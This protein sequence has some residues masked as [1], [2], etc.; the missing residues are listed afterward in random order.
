MYH[1]ARQD[2][3]R[4]Q[5]PAANGTLL[6]T[7]DAAMQLVARGPTTINFRP[8]G[9]MLTGSIQETADELQSVYRALSVLTRALHP[10]LGALVGPDA[11]KL[12]G[13][14]IPADEPVFLLRSSDVHA[15]DAVR[16]WAR[17]TYD[18][19]KGNA[20][21]ARLAA[22]QAEAMQNWGEQHAAHIADIARH[23]PQGGP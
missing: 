2:Y 3:S 21:L 12:P 15:P 10:T 17:L 4:I 7:F 16:Q 23:D 6:F 18:R 11:A 1:G 19:G 14:P 5:D 20:E 13:K 22:I 8:V 9:A